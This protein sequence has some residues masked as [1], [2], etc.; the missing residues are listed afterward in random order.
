MKRIA[1][2][3]LVACLSVTVN[4]SFATET[5]KISDMMFTNTI[6]DQYGFT[7]EGWSSISRLRATMTMA[8]AIDFMFDNHSQA[9]IDDVAYL[10]TSYFAE[11]DGMI[12]VLLRGRNYLSGYSIM[13]MYTPEEKTGAYCLYSET[14]DGSFAMLKETAIKVYETVYEND[15]SEMLTFCNATGMNYYV[16]YDDQTEESAVEEIQSSIGLTSVADIGREFNNGLISFKETKKWGYLNK[17]G[18]IEIPAKWDYAYDFSEGYAVVFDGSL[19]EDGKPQYGKYGVIGTDGEYVI[20]LMD[21]EDISAYEPLKN[22]ISITYVN[23]EGDL[24]W[25]FWKTD[26]TRIGNHRWDNYYDADGDDY[27]CA[28]VNGKWGFFNRKT[29]DDVIDY[30][31]DNAERFSGNIAC[32]SSRRKN[33]TMDYYYIDRAGNVVI[34]NKGWDIALSFPSGHNVTAVF[35]GTTLYDGEIA[36]EGKYALI[37]RNGDYLCDYVWDKVS[38]NDNGMIVVAK[39]DGGRC[40]YGVINEQLNT[41]VEPAWDYIGAFSQGF[42][43]VFRGTLTK[44]GSPDN[45]LHS[46]IDSSGTMISDLIWSE[47]YH[48]HP[49]SYA[50]VGIKD[51][52]GKELFGVINEKGELVVEPK[53]DDIPGHKYVLA[54]F[55]DD[56]TVVEVD[57]KYGYID[58]SGNVIV[59]PIWDKAEQFSEGLAVVWRDD[60]WHIIN[61]KGEIIR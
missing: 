34:E 10:D 51:S 59:E 60:E 32:V 43:E 55:H 11:S 38:M 47:A 56:L 12:I 61:S 14:E 13:I 54:L 17:E 49:D 23:K 3:A 50:V 24:E 7:S 8:L 58:S 30:Q 33:L 37:N 20:P 19:T 22:D 28:S 41:I 2:L 1:L 27:V 5:V 25:E 18:N 44:Y 15:L 16:E 31:Y 46:F 57:M 21:C 45:G 40:L 39:K 52:A 48:F 42:C 53:Y 26:G 29:G 4:L 9:S 35:K 6:Q 36:D